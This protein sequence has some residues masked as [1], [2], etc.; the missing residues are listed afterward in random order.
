MT[1]E[2]KSGFVSTSLAVVAFGVAFGYVEAAV[3]V[4]LRA[5]LGIV[6]GA[7]PAH[8]QGTFGTFEAVEVAR[9]LA[10]LVMI[11]AVGT[12]AGRTRL[13]RPR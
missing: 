3:V 8:D 4:Y 6:P 1:A 5:A 12:L 7:V 9:E 2:P 10:T 11:V 13:E